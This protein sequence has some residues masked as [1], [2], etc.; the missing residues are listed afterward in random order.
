MELA[1]VA[2]VNKTFSEA[3]LDVL[4]RRLYIGL[5]PLVKLFSV[6]YEDREYPEDIANY[7]QDDSEVTLKGYEALVLKRPIEPRQ[8]TRFQFYARRVRFLSYQENLQRIDPSVLYAIGSYAQPEAV[9]PHLHELHWAQHQLHGGELLYFISP[10][11]VSLSLKVFDYIRSEGA[12]RITETLFPR[13]DDSNEH[14]LLAAVHSRA[15][16]VRKVDLYG[17][18]IKAPLVH[19]LQFRDLREI[20]LGRYYHITSE[21]LSA[22]SA[23]ETLEALSFEL[24]NLK[25]SELSI[26]EGFPAL[27]QL[28]M[29]CT[30]AA[31]WCSVSSMLSVISSRNLSKLSINFEFPPPDGWPSGACH[32]SSPL[33]LLS[34]RWRCSMQAFLLRITTQ[35]PPPVEHYFAQ[36]SDIIGPLMPLSRLRAV[37][38]HIGHIMDASFALRSEDIPALAGAWPELE[39]FHLSTDRGGSSHRVVH[40]T[41]APSIYSLVHFALKCPSLRSLKLPCTDLRPVEISSE[42]PAG[43]QHK[44]RHLQAAEVLPKAHQSL[45]APAARFL[46]ETFPLVC[47]DPPFQDDFRKVVTAWKRVRVRESHSAAARLVRSRTTR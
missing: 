35:V 14:L 25:H 2:L 20:S 26:S 29:R 4:W 44:L 45:L 9:I 28:C 27:K 15:S 30:Q 13:K 3:A 19:I 12:L 24:P 18:P 16:H 5:L 34:Q 31:C 43:L 11:L 7:D 23:S 8:W 10:N 37:H 32:C 22:F 6:S 17:W 40:S 46:E 21:A 36:L 39:E 47:L 41:I 1:H 33:L 42:V 38:I